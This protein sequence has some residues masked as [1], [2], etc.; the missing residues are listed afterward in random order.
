MAQRFPWRMSV[1]RS[2]A[3]SSLGDTKVFGDTL[4]SYFIKAFFPGFLAR[5]ACAG[6]PATAAA[7]A[8]PSSVLRL[9]GERIGGLQNRFR[10][11]G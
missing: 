5:A 10:V 11:E 2:I 1:I 9:T 3:L 6:T 7:A 4:A 8:V